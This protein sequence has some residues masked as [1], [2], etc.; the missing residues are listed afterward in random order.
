VALTDNVSQIPVSGQLDFSLR[1]QGYSRIALIAWHEHLLLKPS[2]GSK[3][4]SLDGV[5]S[6]TEDFASL[7]E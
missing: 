1:A 6:C 2:A 3:K 7:F 5:G 4:S